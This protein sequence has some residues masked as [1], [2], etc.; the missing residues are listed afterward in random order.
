MTSGEKRKKITQ[1]RRECGVRAEE[2]K[3][4]NSAVKQMARKKGTA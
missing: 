4:S 3:S 1:G 2:E